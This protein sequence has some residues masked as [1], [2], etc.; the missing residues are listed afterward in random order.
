MYPCLSTPVS[1]MIMTRFTF[2]Y[3]TR[4]IQHT[5]SLLQTVTRRGTNLS[6]NGHQRVFSFRSRSPFRSLRDQTATLGLEG[7]SGV[8]K[9]S[10]V[11][12]FTTTLCRLPTTYEVTIL[13][14][15]S[16]SDR[17]STNPTA[18]HATNAD[19]LSYHQDL[20]PLLL[21]HSTQSIY[22]TTPSPTTHQI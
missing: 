11:T 1:F 18:D 14:I 12:T 4:L 19:H 20:Y 5:T 9:Y 2:N 21:K 17:D 3:K 16:T 6:F 8:K 22:P 10:L 7:T 13:L 15:L